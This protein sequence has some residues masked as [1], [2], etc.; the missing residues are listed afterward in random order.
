MWYIKCK[1]HV[2]KYMIIDLN[3]GIAFLSQKINPFFVNL[4]AS[5]A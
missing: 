3:V 5:I 2:S 4:Y 1:K